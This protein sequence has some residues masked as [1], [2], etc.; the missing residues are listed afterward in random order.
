MDREI[1]TK[2]ERDEERKREID[3]WRERE[4]QRHM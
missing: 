4:T 3:G 2:R 1:W